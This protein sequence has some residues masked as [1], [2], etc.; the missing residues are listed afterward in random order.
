MNEQ[1]KPKVWRPGRKENLSTVTARW[2]PVTGALMSGLA[3]RRGGERQAK[4]KESGEEEALPR[5]LDL[6]SGNAEPVAGSR[7]TAVPSGL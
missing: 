5:G 4:I 2:T 6:I 7:Q 1:P 3:V